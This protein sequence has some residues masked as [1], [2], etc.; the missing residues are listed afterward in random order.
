MQMSSACLI[1]WVQHP[2]ELTVTTSQTTSQNPLCVDYPL[3]DLVTHASITSLSTHQWT[4]MLSS[5]FILKAV[6]RCRTILTE[7]KLPW[8]AVHV[9]GF[10][11]T[12]LSFW[13]PVCD[14]GRTP[15]DRLV[16]YDHAVLDDLSGEN[17]FL[18]LL[19]QNDQFVLFVAAGSGESF[20][21]L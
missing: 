20:R 10:T 19:L 12:P 3:Q 11:D 16:E 1:G 5:H 17:D 21:T 9:H 6:S 15:F 2:L 4:G 18:L 14:D 13:S 7:K 8:I